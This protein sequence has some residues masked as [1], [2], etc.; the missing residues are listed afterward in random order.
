M[1][2]IPSCILPQYLWYNKSIQVDKASIHFLTFSEKS[3]NYVS[4]LFS[5]NGLLKNSMNLRENTTYM[6]VHIL[7]ATISRFYFRKM[8]ICYQR[9][10]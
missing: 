10:L 3:V 4:Q 8:E 1:A 6:G 5:D 2:E 9:K 7:M